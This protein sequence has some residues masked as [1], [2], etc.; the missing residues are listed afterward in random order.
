[1]SKGKVIAAVVALL[2]IGG[3]AAAVVLG[4]SAGAPEVTVEQATQSSLAVTVSAS[5]KTESDTKGDIYP[6]TA[7][8]LASIEVTDGQVVK[9]GDIIAT[10]DTTPLELQVAQAQAAYQGALAQSDSISQSSPSS[11][12]KAAASASVTAAYNGYKAALDQYNA[13]KNVAPD[14]TAIAQAETAVATSK[15]TYDAAQAAYD[16]YK[17]NVYDPA[18]LPRD[19]SMETALAI[20][21]L[22]RDQAYAN[23]AASQQALAALLAGQNTNVAL[24]AARSAKDQ[25]WAAYQGAL[26]QQ[27]KLSSANTN[28]A[29]SSANA[30]V[31]AA[32]EALDYAIENLEKATMRAP[33]DGTVVFNGAGSSLGVAGLGASAGGKPVVGSSVSPAAAPFSVVYFDQLVFNAQVDEA[34]IATI[35]PGLKAAV[36]LDA[37]PGDTLESTVE[38]VD[39]TSVVTPTGGTAFSVIIRL[40][41]T[42]DEL[43]L[44]M[45]G[46][47]DIE[48]ESI[49]G[50]LTVPV[51]AVLDESGKSYVFVAENGKAKRVEVTT[52]RLTDTRA[53]IMSGLSEGANVIVSGIGD[54]K[55]GAAIRVK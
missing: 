8:I 14:P 28:A 20:L 35:K 9:E 11:A 41:G 22:A 46:S 38:R 50:A 29:K 16:S 43:F 7:G 53:E 32:R 49:A 30:A 37:Y 5:G 24:A 55:D 23:Y 6:P 36:T 40:S 45:N 51:E 13:L 4:R 44:G 34:D 15:A 12:D 17:T 18:P 54:L 39:K 3:I 42:G 19:A 1:M 27:A 52:G 31:S 10:M 25:G 21:S 33:H 48:I 2:I 26:A 47:T